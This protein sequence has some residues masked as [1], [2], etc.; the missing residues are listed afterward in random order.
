MQ[1]SPQ[2]FV[3]LYSLKVATDTAAGV[4]KQL[5][6]MTSLKNATEC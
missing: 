6:L 5:A 2:Y 4:T 1:I 3:I